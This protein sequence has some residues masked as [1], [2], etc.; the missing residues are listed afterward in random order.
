TTVPLEEFGESQLQERL[1]DPV[2]LEEHAREHEEVLQ[3][4]LSSTTVVPFRFGAVYLDAD[5]VRELLRDRGTELRAALDRV[6]G[7]VE[8]GVKL[9]A[10]PAEVEAHLA[11]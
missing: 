6:R 7:C 9:W 4:V 11:P 8:L 3:R 10:D 1:N 2:W 5:G